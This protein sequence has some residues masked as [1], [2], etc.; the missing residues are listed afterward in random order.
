MTT[1]PIP[2]LSWSSYNYWRT[3]GKAAWYDSKF[4]GNAY[5]PNKLMLLG[6]RVADSMVQTVPLVPFTRL[7]YIEHKFECEYQDIPLLGFAD[8]FCLDS[9][10]LGEFKTGMFADVWGHP[11]WTQKRADAHG[12]LRFYALCAMIQHNII[13]EDLH[14]FLEWKPVIMKDW[15]F[16]LSDLPIQRFE[17]QLTLEDVAKF[18]KSL[19]R[20]W[21]SMN[22]Y[23]AERRADEAVDSKV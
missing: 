1:S 2:H 4:C 15:D 11:G 3:A 17:V 6:S 18:G 21:K 23:V 9:K 16:I 5:K 14:I 20:T 7:T 19:V 12:Q 22:E 10:T 13:P 8:T